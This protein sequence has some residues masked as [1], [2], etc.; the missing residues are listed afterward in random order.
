MMILFYLF[1]GNFWVWFSRI[2]LRAKAIESR[3]SIFTDSVWTTRFAQNFTFVDVYVIIRSKYTDDSEKILRMKNYHDI[4]LSDHRCNLPCKSIRNF[5]TY[6]YRHYCFRMVSVRIHLR[7]L[8]TKSSVIKIYIF[9]IL[10]IVKKVDRYKCK[11]KCNRF[12][13]TV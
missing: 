5:P 13:Y 7:L 11:N 1:A 10:I 6:P 3:T 4:L 12:N 8:R 9:H 2:S